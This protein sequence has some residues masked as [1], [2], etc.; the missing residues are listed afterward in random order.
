MWPRASE[1]H[2]ERVHRPAY[3]L[4]QRNSSLPPT[5][6]ASQSCPS[7]KQLQRLKQLSMLRSKSR[8]R[9]ITQ[10]CTQM[11]AT[12]LRSTMAFSARWSK[13]ISRYV[14]DPRSMLIVLDVCPRWD[15]RDWF[16]LD[17]WRSHSLWRTTS[18]SNRLCTDGK[19]HLG[20]DDGFRRDGCICSCVWRMGSSRQSPSG[21]H[22]R[23]R[24]TCQADR[25]FHPSVGFAVGW[26]NVLHGLFSTPS[27]LVTISILCSYWD[28]AFPT[29]HQAAYIVAAFVGLV[30]FA[31]LV[32]AVQSKTLMS[33]TISACG[34]GESQSLSSLAPR[35]YSS[36]F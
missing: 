5:S 8:K 21:S 28:T 23:T 32:P 7:S 3:T 16:V 35:S 2:K 11:R 17:F 14:T 19:R 34:G 24:L 26:L 30:I 12:Y 18:C 20:H 29:S 27:E 36:S 25:W 33:R 6:L 22:C 15:H 4:Y 9:K 13:D 10:S 31:S 1:A